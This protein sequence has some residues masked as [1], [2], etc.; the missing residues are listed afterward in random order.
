MISKTIIVRNLQK[1]LLVIPALIPRFSKFAIM[2]FNFPVLLQIILI[3]IFP[4]FCP[5]SAT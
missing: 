3:F 1:K 5:G 2:S 4:P